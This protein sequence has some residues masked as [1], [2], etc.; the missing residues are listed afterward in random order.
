MAKK[1]ADKADKHGKNKA[2]ARSG[3]EYD[4][5]L[6]EL[7]VELVKLQKDVIANNRKLL[8]I[9]EGRDGAGKDGTIQRITEHMSPRE[10]RVVA[11]SKPSDREVTQW[12][13]QRYTFWLPSA[14][15]IVLF[16][17]SWY[18]RAGVER[19]MGFCTDAEYERFM[20]T[21]TTY[22]EM[23]IGS[24][25]EMLK[26]YLDISKAEQKKRLAARRKDPLKQW[27]ISPI[28][29]AAQK[30]WDDYT[31]A[32][33]AMFAR[34]HTLLSPWHIVCANDKKVA[35]LNVIRDILNRVD[36]EGKKKHIVPD[37][38]IVFAFDQAHYK[39]GLIAK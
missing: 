26:Y 20:A 17:R 19:V 35:R 32:R 37:A 3:E 16:N 24:G 27:K 34:T 14:D 31:K 30:K 5:A 4:Q 36:Y 25:V 39:S 8:I 15:E 6:Y 18:N 29:E 1:K 9:M 21:V 28:D 33:D 2:D 10:T 13:F 38:E 22:E 11:L 7:Q 12:Y 23:L